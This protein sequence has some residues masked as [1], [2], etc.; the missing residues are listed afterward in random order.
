MERIMWL[1][2]GGVVLVA[3]VRAGRHARALLVARWAL[4]LLFVVFGA[5]VN[6]LY[7]VLDPDYYTDFAEPSPFGFVRDTWDSLVVPHLGLFIT[8]LI[9]AEAV[10][11]AL[12]LSGG[13]RAQAG[14]IAL[15]AFHVGQ[16]A[17][18]GV[19]WVWAPLMLVALGL[20]LRAE[21]RATASGTP[22]R[23]DGRARWA[24]TARRRVLR[25][26]S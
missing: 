1:V 5:L 14:L 26:S 12:I 2:L 9:V 10:A 11:G 3:A 21:R 16:L 17:F 24:W 7:L 25:R 18:G 4:G 15:I 8:I 13:R 22:T 6:A 20:L 19:L 23:R